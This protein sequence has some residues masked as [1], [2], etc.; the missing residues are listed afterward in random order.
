MAD[1]S[2]VEGYAILWEGLTSIGLSEA[3]DTGWS[4]LVV[5]KTADLICYWPF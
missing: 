5:G 3:T 4:G 1:D 2:S